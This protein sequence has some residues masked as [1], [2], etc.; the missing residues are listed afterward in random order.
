[1]MNIRNLKDDVMS[2]INNCALTH[3]QAMTSLSSIPRNHVEFFETTPKF[4]CE[5]EAGNLCRYAE[6]VRG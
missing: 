6:V 5:S 1:M 4:L 3:E 2:V